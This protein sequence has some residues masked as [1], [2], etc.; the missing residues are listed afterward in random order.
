M[1]KLPFARLVREILQEQKLGDDQIRV[2]AKALEAFQEAA[3]A[4]L[5]GFFEGIL[6]Q[7]LAFL[8]YTN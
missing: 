5:T 2:Q 6:Y 3:E 1:R 4:F 8:L 7:M